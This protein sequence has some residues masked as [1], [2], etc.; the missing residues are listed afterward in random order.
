M[1]PPP[2]LQSKEWLWKLAFYVHLTKKASSFPVVVPIEVLG[3]LYIHF[4]TVSLIFII[5]NKYKNLSLLEFYQSEQTI[6]NLLVVFI[7][8]T[9]CPKSNTQRVYLISI[10]N[11]YNLWQIT[12]NNWNRYTKALCLLYTIIML[13][14]ELFL[15]VQVVPTHPREYCW[16]PSGIFPV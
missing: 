9:H 15:W 2:E 3:T 4:D 1:N 16:N 14:E 12:H 13:V 7:A 11:W 6:W 8:T 10:C 5:T